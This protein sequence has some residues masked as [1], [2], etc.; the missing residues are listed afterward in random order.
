MV[1]ANKVPV[2]VVVVFYSRYGETERVAL[3]AG[4]GAVQARANIRLRRL[5]D[6]AGADVI[7]RDPSWK[8]NLERMTPEYIAPRPIDI[9]WAEVLILAAPPDSA[10][11]MERFL[12]A[13]ESCRGK[14]G[15]PVTSDSFP[16]AAAAKAELTI[17]PLASHG[18]DR[19]GA[20]RAHG[21]HV[22]EIAR[23]LKS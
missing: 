8:E 1:P 5:P 12:S 9:E 14:I 18:P 21:K 20:A 4:V 17:V 22:A 7:A 19:L 13:L 11:E 15:A 3:A 23:K 6:I 2:N 16:Y 10:A